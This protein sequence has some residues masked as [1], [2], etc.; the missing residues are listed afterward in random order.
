MDEN[1]IESLSNETLV[2][3][4]VDVT[5]TLNYNHYQPSSNEV[6]DAT[7]RRLRKL[8]SALRSEILRRLANG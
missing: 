6:I 1:T 8:Q 3:E 4:L 5:E 7:Y 2:Y